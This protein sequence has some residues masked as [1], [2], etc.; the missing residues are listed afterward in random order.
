EGA[1]AAQEAATAL[2][3][4][5]PLLKVIERLR[6]TLPSENARWAVTLADG[7]ASAHAKFKD[8]AHLFFD[9]ASAEQATSETVATHTAARFAGASRIAD[10]GCGAGADALALAEQAPVLAVDLD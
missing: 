10:L 9:R 1:S 3:G 8:A 2:S 4:G 5:T 7:R 6:R